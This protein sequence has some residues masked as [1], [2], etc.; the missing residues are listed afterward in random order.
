MQAFIFD[1]ATFMREF[2]EIRPLIWMCRARRSKDLYRT[3]DG[4]AK[5]DDVLYVLANASRFRR[6]SGG[7][8]PGPDWTK[9]PQSDV[10]DMCSTLESSC[11]RTYKENITDFFGT[12]LGSMRSVVLSS[13]D[14]TKRLGANK[15][16]VS[17]W[18]GFI[19]CSVCKPVWLVS[20]YSF[21]VPCNWLSLHPMLPISG[22]YLGQDFVMARLLTI[23]DAWN[24]AKHLRSWNHPSGLPIN[25]WRRSAIKSRT[26][27]V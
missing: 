10:L 13:F 8:W 21:C 25:W 15:F 26:V 2:K 9:I 12:N 24:L 5:V 14:Q 1:F 22:P 18:R 20:L 17:P 19:L 27:W 16:W 11:S 23:V 3:E 4:Y 7:H 6:V